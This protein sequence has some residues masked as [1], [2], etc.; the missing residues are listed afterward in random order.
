MV[1]RRDERLR[2]HAL[3]EGLG[4][5]THLA[6]WCEHVLAAGV[7]SLR[8]REPKW[9][10]AEVRRACE[11]LRPRCEAHGALLLVTGHAECVTA[12]LA[13]GLQVGARHPDVADLRETIGPAAWLGFSAHDP[14]QLAAAAAIG[15]DFAL[16]APVWATASKPGQAPLGPECAA[17]WTR[18]AALPVLWLGGVDAD[19]AATLRSLAAE[20]RPFGLAGIGAFAAV[21]AASTVTRLR[22]ALTESV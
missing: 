13:D 1:G 15:C 7:R 8:L 3:S 2:L 14:E 9:S 19:A 12:G 17:R 11:R 16:L 4:D 5:A 18:S 22:D 21:A 6:E 10:A 20:D